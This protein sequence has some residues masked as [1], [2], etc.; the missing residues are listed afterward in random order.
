MNAI[1]TALGLRRSELLERRAFIG[2]AWVEGDADI[3]VFNPA[4]GELL[5]SVP[6]LGEIETEAAVCAAADALPAWKCRPAAE[7][8]AI[9]RRYAELLRDNQECLARILTA[10]QGKPLR[11][12][13]GE[14]LYAAAFL[15]WF[16]EEAKRIYGET[17]PAPQAD[18]RLM[19][20]RQAV[21]VV[22]AITPWNFPAAMITRKLGPA[23]AAGCT[24]VLK[25][26]ELAPL[27]ALS[28]ARLAQ[29]AGVPDGVFNVVTGRPQEIGAVL[30]RHRQVRKLSFTGSTAVGKGLIEQCASTV[31]R[32]SME[33]GGN[34]PFLIFESADLDQA[35]QGVIESKFRN[36]GQTCVCANRILVQDSVHDRFAELLRARVA[37]MAVGDGRR[38]D[39]DI[40]PLI[41]AA[42]RAKVEAHVTDAVAQ[43]AEVLVGGSPDTAGEL[44]FQPTVLANAH[45]GMLVF[46]EETFGPVAP[47]FRFRDEAEAIAMANDTPAGL[48][49][50]AFTTD[51]GQYHRIVEGLEYGMVGIN[52]GLISTEVAPFGGIK[53]SGMGREGSRHGL[54]DYL[55]LKTV[56]TRI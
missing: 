15:D 41:N 25:P 26:S 54:D 28:L 21:G 52:T 40:G 22:A 45:P 44:F 16:G 34:A 35:V 4:T 2:G 56:C 8:S 42:A 19:V 1:A 48:A 23:L 51:L 6:D 30:T 46:R 31:K 7:R 24:M 3:P 50:Y 18:R 39:V 27:T 14:I 32:V 12:A 43:G 36:A 47:L 37:A 11:E 55:N 13:R 17:I 38:E 53:E 9:L 49:C 20:I 33:L 10:E 29:E 5:A